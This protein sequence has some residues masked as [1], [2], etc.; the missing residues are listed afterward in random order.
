MGMEERVTM[1]LG[2]GKKHEREG[3]AGGDGEWE[4][5]EG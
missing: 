4:V 1:G 5:E 3:E 2:G